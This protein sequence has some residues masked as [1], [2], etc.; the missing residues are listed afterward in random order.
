VEPVAICWR[1]TA[2]GADIFGTEDQFYF[3][4]AD[5]ELSGDF[6]AMVAWKGS[7]PRPIAHEWAKAGIMARQNLE[8]GSPHVMVVHTPGNGVVFQGRDVQSGESWSVPVGFADWRVNEVEKVWLRLDRVGNT[9]TGSY[10]IGGET[11]PEV[12]TASASHEVAFGDT[13]VGLA[14]TSHKQGVPITVTYTDLYIWYGG[15]LYPG[16]AAGNPGGAGHMGIL[17][18]IDNGQINDQAACYDSLFSGMGTIVDYTASVLNI[19]D[20][21]DN[22]HYGN[23]DVFGVVTAGYRVHETV[24]N[25]SLI[26]RGAIRIPRS[27]RGQGSYWTFG[28]N[29]DDG[30]TLQLPGQ[31]FI[32]AVGGEIVEFESG[33]ALRF[34]GGR[35]AADTLGVIYL[36]PGDHAFWLTYH[37]GGVASAVELFAAKGAHTAF[38]PAAFRLVG[39]PDVLQLMAQPIA[40]WNFDEGE[41]IIAYDCSGFGYNATLVGDPCWVAA[42]PI[43]IPGIALEFDGIDDSVL[44]PPI[45]SSVEFTYAMWL[46]PAELRAGYTSLMTTTH[47]DA[48]AVHWGLLDGKPKIGI[49]G[50]VTPGGD[51]VAAQPIEIPRWAHIAVVKSPTFLAHYV[52]GEEVA[53]RE[54]TQSGEVILGQAKISDWQGERRF[55][56]M[57][58]DVRIYNRALSPEEIADLFHPTE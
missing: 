5:V 54:L 13:Q 24:D 52:N 35:G 20:S 36:P 18:V 33:A 46:K 56:G 26:A 21:G 29:S 45:G 12:W 27:P 3:A 19:Q 11:L 22:G 39:D 10:A 4:Y 53:A 50:V 25:I 1:I 57:M 44:I 2:G 32:S 43:N 48:G 17:E 31:N 34:Y 15:G 7:P 51:L 55:K 41:G 9:F 38:D 37:E 6:S 49:N 16:M 40:R 30:F 14:T 58:D 28:V 47:W 42:I 23:D 8:P